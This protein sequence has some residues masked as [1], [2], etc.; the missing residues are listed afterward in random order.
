[1][2]LGRA[3]SPALLFANDLTVL[4]MFHPSGCDLDFSG[5]GP[6]EGRELSRDGGDR[7]IGVL[8]PRDQTPVALAQAHLGLP[9][10]VLDALG[11][12]LLSLLDQGRDPGRVAIGPGPFDQ[13]AAGVAVSGLGD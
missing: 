1:M 11:E 5:N 12:M 10:D 6:D 8:A 2:N 3:P 4:F 13:D 7:H 9:G